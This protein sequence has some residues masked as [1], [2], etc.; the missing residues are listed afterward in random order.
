MDNHDQ[1]GQDDAQAEFEAITSQEEFDKRLGQRINRERAKFADY[2]DLKAKAARLDEIEQA[3]KSE[4]EK[5]NERA[6]RLE[7]ELEQE[8]VTSLRARLAA[9]AGMPPAIVT[10]ND[11]E[12]ILASIAGLKEWAGKADA[13]KSPAPNPYQ[14]RGATNTTADEAARTVLGI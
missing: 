9:E 13:P 2:D 5:A 10:G 4:I 8:R 1:A 11:E 3:N 14:G 12:S 6:A 7:A